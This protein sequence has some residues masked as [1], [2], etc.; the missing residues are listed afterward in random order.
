MSYECISCG[1][2]FSQ[3]NFTKHLIEDKECWI[4][5]WD[6]GNNKTNDEKKLESH[7]RIHSQKQEESNIIGPEPFLS[8]NTYGKHSSTSSGIQ[9]RKNILYEYD[10]Y[11][12]KF[13]TE[14]E[15]T[16]H[17]TQKHKGVMHQCDHCNYE[18]N[19]EKHLM[20]HIRCVHPNIQ[21]VTNSAKPGPSWE[22]DQCGKHSNRNSC[23]E[24]NRPYECDV[25]DQRFH[26][27]YGLIYHYKNAHRRLMYQCEHCIYGTNDEEDM[28]SHIRDH[29]NNQEESIIIDPEPSLENDPGVKHSRE[30]SCI[31]NMLHEYDVCNQKFRQINEEHLKSQVQCVHPN[32]QEENNSAEP[33][34]SWESVPGVKHSKTNSCIENMLHEYD[35]CNQ[36][37]REINEE[38]LKSQ[39]QCVHLNIQEENNSAE[40]GPS[41]ESVPGV[42]H[43]KTN[44]CIENM[45]HEYDVCNQKF[46]E[47][48]EEHLK[49]QV[50][51]VHPNIQEENNSAE[52]GPS[53]ESVPG[54]KHS[55]TSSCIENMLH[56]YDVC[57]QKF[58][59]I[60]EEHLKSQVQC[61]HPNIQEENNSAEPGPSWESVPGVKHSKTNS[62]IEN[63]LHEYDVCN[64]KFREINEEHLKSQVQCVHPNIQEE[65]NSAE[66]GPSWESVPGVKHSKT[67]SCIENMLHEYDVC[68]QKF[69]EINEE[70]LKSQ[71]QCVHPNIQE[72]NNSAEPGPSWESVPGVKHSKTNSCI[73][74][75]LHEYDVCNQMFRE[76]NEEHLKSQVQCVH[77]NIQEEN[78]S[79]EPGPSWES[80]P[81]VKHSK[82]NSCIENM[83]H[84]Y[85]VCNQKFR[86]INEEHLKSQVQCVHPNIQEENNSA[87][88]GP[89]WES[90]PGVK[91]SKTNSCIE[92]MLHEY[93][94]CNQK[95]RE[96]NEEHLKSQVQCVHPN[97][98]EE[99]N[100]AEPGPSWES[101]PGVKHSKTNSCI[102]NMLHEYDVCNQKFREINEEHVESQ[103]QC[104]HPNIQEEDNSAEPGP[105]WESDTYGKHSSRNSCSE[106]NMPYECTVCNQRFYRT[107]TLTN[108]Y[109]NVHQRLMPHCEHRAYET[110]DKNLKDHVRRVY[111]NVQKESNSSEPGPSRESEPCAKYT[112]INNNKKKY[113][114]DWKC[115][116]CNQEHSGN[117]KLMHH[118]AEVHGIQAKFNCS[119]CNYK[120]HFYYIY[121][122]HWKAMHEDNYDYPCTEPGCERAYKTRT[123][124]QK[125]MRDKHSNEQEKS[126]IVDLKLS[127]ESHPC[128][129]HSTRKS[130][131]EKYAKKPVLCPVCNRRFRFQKELIDHL[132]KDHGRRTIFNC[133]HCSYATNNRQSYKKHNKRMHE[134]NYDYVCSVP[135]CNWE[136]K[137]QCDLTQHMQRVHHNNQKKSG[138]TNAEPSFENDSRIKQSRIRNKQQ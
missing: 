78:N 103:L 95:F 97:I 137:V 85:D 25:C 108:H 84:E 101:V 39:V 138:S 67:N 133:I 96:I 71:V 7:I 18:F 16:N 112:S 65:N 8:S 55:K 99:N 120:T 37:F 24:N 106:N 90:V 111:P 23:I 81:G 117:Q 52:P 10:D 113:K 1:Q 3:M 68:N 115:Q 19:D 17:L 29:S 107:L 2:R 5:V 72:E 64:Q 80:V 127:S 34:P 70:H 6:H 121:H 131:V 74:N 114:L 86:E 136:G 69:R 129:K 38:H 9:E 134:D 119:Q 93:D 15:L 41:W 42:K 104:V 56:E 22:D 53:W 92:N 32:I 105:S 128:G 76:I 43:S 20:S 27:R 30:N 36:M 130:S 31:E 75:M 100:S 79:A 11:N 135:N 63:M 122:R 89:S 51:C 48:N 35:V 124:L 45:L 126:N 60:N 33:G 59:E 77:L 46:R 12:Q 47:I 40:P 49:S 62:C 110:N 54:V 87:E 116:V 109:K 13:C 118:L 28:K 50:Q 58:R 102:E 82:T 61:V 83:L 91:H 26:K 94:V 44:S 14:N 88:P 73:E 132:I 57:N 123:G 125:H 4:K 98:Q 66:P 21:E